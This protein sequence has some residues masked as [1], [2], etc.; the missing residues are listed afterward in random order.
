MSELTRVERINKAIE[1]MFISMK[2]KPRDIQ[3]ELA[4]HGHLL[5]LPVVLGIC[6]Q[7]EQKTLCVA[8]RSRV[9]K[10]REAFDKLLQEMSE[11]CRDNKIRYVD[12]QR[13]LMQQGIP[14]PANNEPWLKQGLC[15]YL[16]RR[17]IYVRLRRKGEEAVNFPQAQVLFNQ[18]GFAEKLKPYTSWP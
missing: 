9:D 12:M 16:H 8:D 7:L 14:N 15:K 2:M 3:T 11:F 10:K 17:N 5:D 4:K 1:I 18:A 13:Y 6:T